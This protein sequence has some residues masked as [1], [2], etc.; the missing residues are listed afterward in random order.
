MSYTP[1]Q[2]L[3]NW[4]LRQAPDA[5]QSW[6]DQRRAQV[7]EGDTRALFLAFGMAPR[8]FGKEPLEVSDRDQENATD[9]RDGW[10]PRGWS[11]DQ[12]AR[13]LLLASLPSED[14]SEYMSVLDTLFQTG[15]VRELVA[16]YQALSILPHHELMADRLA[17]GIRTN[18]KSVFCAVAHHNP[19]PREILEI[20]PWNQMILK[21]LFIGVSI[22]RIQ[23]VDQRANLHL[24]RMLI[25][26]AHERRA[27]SRPIPIE[28]WRMVAPFPDETALGDMAALYQQG[29]PLERQAIGLA[30][31]DSATDEADAILKSNPEIVS[32]IEQ[33]DINWQRISLDSE[34]QLA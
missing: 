22:D 9:A 32:R 13:T 23:G 26:Y 17:E 33:G 27:A 19:L 7:A 25:D 21:A 8:K 15:E 29:T 34:S 5:A 24:S 31:A 3:E 10:V 2:L 6:L 1:V 18:M 11:I 14:V 16:L 4:I 20:G 12:A 30:L 28:L